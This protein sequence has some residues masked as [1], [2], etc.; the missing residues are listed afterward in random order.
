MKLEFFGNLRACALAAVLVAPTLT[1]CDSV[2]NLTPQQHV[3]RAK[4]FQDK[5]DLGSSIIELKSALQ[6]SPDNAE[7][8]LLLGENY[9]KAHQGKEAEK[10]LLQAQ[11]L[12]VARSAVLPTLIKAILLQGDLDRVLAESGKLTP[13]MSKAGQATIL[14]LRGQAFI[15]KGQ[16]DLAQQALEQAL[17]IKSDSLPALIGMIALHGYQRHYDVARPWAEKALNADSTSADAWSAL[18]DLEMAQGRLTE[19]EKAYGSAIKHRATPYLEQAK[20]AQVRIQLKKFPEATADIKALQEAGLKDHPYVNYIAGLNYFAQK[21]YQDA[22]TAFE[23]SNAV[24]PSFLSNKIYLATTHLMLGNTEQALT[25]AQKISAV[26]PRSRAAKNLLGSILISRAEYDDAKDILQKTL[27]NS[28]NDPQ[29]LGMMSTVAMLE[30]DTAKGL[31]YAKKLAALEPDSKQ[32]QDMLMMA[33]LMA[34]EALDQTISQ[35]GKQAATASDAYTQELM[36]ALAS[37]RDSKLKEALERAKAMHARYPDKVDPPKLMA[38]VYLAAAQWEQGKAELEKVL[39]LQ[40]NEPSATRNLAKV[41]ALQ[42]NYQ[43]AKTLL[44]P[45][46][47]NQPGDTEATQL[48]AD[49]ESRLG[50]SAAALEMLEQAAKSKPGDLAIRSKLAA[51][52]LQTGR[53]DKVLEIT[54]GLADAQ[55]RQQP[56]LLELRGKALLLSGDGASSAS[57]FEKWTKI[58]PNS[59]LAHFYYANALAGRGDTARARKELEQAIKLGPRYLPARVGEIKM[60]VQFNELDQAKKALAKLRQDFGDRAEVLGIEG[61]FALGTGDLPAAEQKL[62][63]ALKKAPGSELVILTSRAQWG[64]KKQEPALKTMRDWLKDHPNDVPVHMQLAGAYLDMGRETDSLATYGQVV[65]LAPKHVPALNNLAW[66]NRDKAPQKAMEYAQQAY[67]LAPKDPY[68]LDTL[69]MLTLKNGDLS[70][71]ASLLRDAAKLVPEDAQ[72]QLHLGSVLLQQKQLAEARKV[73]DAIVKKAPGS[74]TAKEATTL[75]GTFASVK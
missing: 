48:L 40:P 47:K 36:L 57:T 67:Q 7:A 62:A 59:A 49:A 29:A 15:A 74:P 71:A 72:V 10:E 58:A 61:W 4:D 23:A 65:K 54:R 5:G 69:G 37:F 18:G 51:E 17:Q 64:Q 63:A 41:E 25:H 1:S 19:A 20:R 14:G 11:K 38:A 56:A 68:V 12:G 16:L 30:G 60:R 50:N 27:A 13:D 53:A 52:Y 75:L 66:L 9:V 21:K 33:K 55:F 31:E 32:A 34:G 3:Q 46:L 73:L 28:P 35:A 2:G 26:A 45:L 39:K 42:G 24:D 44:Q 8:R 70:R 22:V 43:R 6:Q